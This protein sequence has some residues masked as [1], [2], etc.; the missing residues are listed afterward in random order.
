M[1]TRNKP[2]LRKEEWMAATN[3]LLQLID[4]FLTL[5]K[6]TGDIADI[7]Y[8]VYY[9]LGP[10]NLNEGC[11]AYSNAAAAALCQFATNKEIRALFEHISEDDFYVLCQ[12]LKKLVEF[13]N[14]IRC[15]KTNLALLDK[16]R[17]EV[18]EISDDAMKD[19]E[20]EK[21]RY[22]YKLKHLKERISDR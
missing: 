14:N 4:E 10:C 3:E 7:E 8:W 21:A 9:F 22:V 13:C 17:W 5:S 12:M 1:A 15:N 18:G 11:T 6:E 16:C 20:K 19:L 2:S